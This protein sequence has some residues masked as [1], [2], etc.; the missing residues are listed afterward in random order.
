[1]VKIPKQL[2]LKIQITHDENH[3]SNG[4]VYT[5]VKQQLTQSRPINQKHCFEQYKEAD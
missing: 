3:L 4:R 1:L 2:L 5:V